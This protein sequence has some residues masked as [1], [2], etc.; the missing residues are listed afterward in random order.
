MQ[1]CIFPCNHLET[2][3]WNV[4]VTTIMTNAM[5]TMATVMRWLCCWQQPQWDT[6]A[7]TTPHND[8][9]WCGKTKGII[10]SGIVSVWGEGGEMMDTDICWCGYHTTMTITM[11]SIAMTMMT[12]WLA[13]TTTFMATTTTS[14]MD[15][16]KWRAKYTLALAWA[17]YRGGRGERVDGWWWLPQPWQSRR[18]WWQQR[19]W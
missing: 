18:P 19:W 13:M 3:G 5:T 2:N 12:T 16:K 1:W 15:V 10:Y 9:N 4:I 17:L 7:P 8:C 11:T 14:A 6:M